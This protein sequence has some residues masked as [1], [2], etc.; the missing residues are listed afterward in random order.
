MD[1]A[2]YTYTILYY[3]YI[4]VVTYTCLL[5]LQ[6]KIKYVSTQ[7]NNKPRPIEKKKW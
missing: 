3:N 5:C 4:K 2:Y 1:Y 7:N 6:I